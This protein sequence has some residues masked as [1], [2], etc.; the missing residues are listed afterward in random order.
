MLSYF[1]KLRSAQTVEKALDR[2]VE[3][4]IMGAIVGPPGCGKTVP[5][6]HWRRTRG[7]KQIWMEATL[8]GSLQGMIQALAQ[9]LGI[10]VGNLDATALKIAETLAA[11][12]VAVLIDEADFLYW[13]AINKLR[14]I[15]DRARMLRDADDGGAFPLALIG[16]PALRKK[17]TR[18]EE[19]CEQ[20]LRRI[21]EFDQV[22]DLTLQEAQGIL[23]EKWGLD[24]AGEFKLEAGA[25][26]EFLRLSRRSFGWLDKIV[27]LALDLARRNG[28]VVS[29]S[30]VR[31]T[32]RYLVGLE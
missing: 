20:V 9:G 24:G 16:T 1:P 30:I 14:A 21:G 7:I 6:A 5:L 28:K 26:E 11:A 19:R 15:W 25:V 17:L 18:D 12:P 27:P 23:A 22:P 10:A 32:S 4:K 13:T 29:A 31:G 2:I 8:G 3:H